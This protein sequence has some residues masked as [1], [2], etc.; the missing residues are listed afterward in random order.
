M[1]GSGLRMPTLLDS[2][3]TS[4]RSASGAI[5]P[6]GSASPPTPGTTKLFVSIA[7]FSRSW[8]R[9]RASTIAGRISPDSRANTARPSISWPATRASPSDRSAQPATPTPC[10]APPPPGQ[11]GEPPPVDCVALEP[12]PGV[13]VGI[14]GVEPAQEPV[15]Q[16]V[17]TLVAGE[18][19]ER[20]GED[21]PVEVEDERPE[22]P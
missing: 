7:V 20:A 12:R 8:Q 1:A 18:C 22:F 14:G 9:R 4:N 11:V 15:G 2:I 10:P 17:V 19:L 21:H 6:S 3:T 13:R 16:S 5:A